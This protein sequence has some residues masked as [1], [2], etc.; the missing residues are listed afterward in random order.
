MIKRFNFRFIPLILLA[1]SLFASGCYVYTNPYDPLAAESSL[2][3]TSVTVEFVEVEDNEDK[4]VFDF[5]DVALNLRDVDELTY[6][7]ILSKTLDGFIYD[8]YKQSD[9][10][11]SL[12]EYGRGDWNEWSDVY[13]RIGYRKNYSAPLWSDVFHFSMNC[14]NPIPGGISLSTLPVLDWADTAGAT[15]YEIDYA[16]SEE[17]LDGTAEASTPDSTSSYWEGFSI[18]TGDTIYWRYRGG[19][20]SDDESIHYLWSRTFSFSVKSVP[21]VGDLYAGGYVFYLNG[22]DGMVLTDLKAAEEIKWGP[23]GNDI[24]GD[25]AAAAPELTAIGSGQVNTSAVVA[26]LGQNGGSSYPAK[27]CDELEYRG[28]SDWYLP[29]SGELDE[30][31]NAL[32]AIDWE[33]FRI[34][35][36][37]GGRGA[38]S[39][40]EVDADNVWV[41][42]SEGLFSRN[43]TGYHDVWA[44][45]DFT[46]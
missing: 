25:N 26:G 35:G 7:I 36:V 40:S 13:F 21:E 32:A 1:V 6:C 15:A 11:V 42:H 23:A 41:R 44:V 14:Y 3:L 9:N 33:L 45:R 29:S 39:S 31:R 24:N 8:D 34:G 46:Y 2:D 43:K 22:G 38:W 20:S 17:G 18:S 27:I 30:A 10:R 19:G 16:K 5:E 4:L 37:D 28:W 12:V